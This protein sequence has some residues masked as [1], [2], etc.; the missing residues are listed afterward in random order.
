MLEVNSKFVTFLTPDGEFL[1]SKKVRDHY[2]IGEEISFVAV[3][4]T[5]SLKKSIFQF[6]KLRVVMASSVAAVLL[7]FTVFTF[8]DSQEVYAYMSIDINPSLEA[9]VDKKLRVVSLEAYNSEGE[10]VLDSLKEWMNQPIDSVTT[11]IIQESKESGYYQD[12]SEI[13]IAT[14]I[15]ETESQTL[16]EKLNTNVKDLVQSYKEVNIPITV[17]NS[18]NEERELA[19]QKG[20]STG[21]Y[22]REIIVAKEKE[23]EKD[24]SSDLEDDKEK[25]DPNKE[26][27]KLNKATEKVPAQIDQKQGNE[28]ASTEKKQELPKVE[29]KDKVKVGVTSGS[30]ATSREKEKNPP[31]AVQEILKKVKEKRDQ[32]DREDDEDDEDDDHEK[33]DE[34]ANDD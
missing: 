32:Q 10:L 1:K 30:S 26:A 20:I 3:N 31:E 22:K 23:L 18:T 14:V 11:A 16:E 29:N 5:Y 13:I 9:G 28:H 25:V 2:E 27:D 6:E 4:E 12:G 17:L 15:V 34:D 7:F 19:H 21:K 24:I 8:Y 33:D